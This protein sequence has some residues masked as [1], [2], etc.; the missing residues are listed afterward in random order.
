MAGRR[1][2]R[3]GIVR[4]LSPAPSAARPLHCLRLFRPRREQHPYRYSVRRC[5]R[6]Y[7]WS[8][9][10]PDHLAVGICAQADV[11]T[12][13]TLRPI[14]ERWIRE[15]VSGGTLERYAWPIPSLGVAALE[16]E[17]PAKDSW[18]L[19][20]DA[21]GLVDP[22]TRE[23]LRTMEPCCEGRWP[24]MNCHDWATSAAGRARRTMAPS[25]IGQ[26]APPPPWR[27]R[28]APGRN[29]NTART[30]A[31]FLQVE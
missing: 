22:I 5:A 26:P 14:V 29:H 12:V 9:P 16:R 30:F 11:A 23:G 17:R 1:R 25:L 4:K 21:A 19:I 31:L 20:G 18:M 3:N 8:F 2:R 6:R 28:P 10:R 7:L 24:I 27:K 13:D 15:N